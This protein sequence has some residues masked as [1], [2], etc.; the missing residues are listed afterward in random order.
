[1]T[2]FD[3]LFCYAPSA[4]LAMAAAVLLFLAFGGEIW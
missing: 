1:M 4:V 3:F 2:Q